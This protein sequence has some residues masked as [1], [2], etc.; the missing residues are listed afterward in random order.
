MTE[1]LEPYGSS[2]EVL[3]ALQL[4]D[5]GIPFEREYKPIPG[6]KYRYDFYFQPDLLVE[7]NGG[8]FQHMGH[9]SPL[10]IQRDYDKHNF[11]VLAGYRVLMFS[12]EDVQ[13]SKALVTTMK[14]LGWE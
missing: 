2:L 13:G 9:S 11:A 6:R 8:T 3:Y 4:R 14:A 7:I 10:G 5:A 12:G 1:P